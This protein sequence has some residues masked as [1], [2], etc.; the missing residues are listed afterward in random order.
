MFDSFLDHISHVC[1]MRGVFIWRTIGCWDSIGNWGNSGRVDCW[2]SF[3]GM[4]H[5]WLRISRVLHCLGMVGKKDRDTV[6]TWFD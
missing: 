5:N 6:L 4:N 3:M 2:S 1:F